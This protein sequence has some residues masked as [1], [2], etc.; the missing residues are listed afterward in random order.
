[1]STNR[2]RLRISV[3]FLTLAAMAAS[4]AATLAAQK[5]AAAPPRMASEVSHF[6]LTPEVFGR[7]VKAEGNLAVLSESDPTLIATIASHPS[8]EVRADWVRRTE[9]RP[10]KAE[11]IQKAGLSPREYLLVAGAL[12][13]AYTVA[14]RKA[15]GK[16]IPKELDGTVPAQNVEFVQAHMAEVD[17]WHRTVTGPS[18]KVNTME[19][20]YSPPG[21][22]TTAAIEKTAAPE[23]TGAA[24]ASAPEKKDKK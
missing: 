23:K 5:E 20:I 12:V 14:A 22:E 3:T 13:Q 11:A 21:A 16:P 24:P 1:M 15:S 17:G 10:Q 9:T 19:D 6:L 4:G 8:D 2:T 7:F 18:G